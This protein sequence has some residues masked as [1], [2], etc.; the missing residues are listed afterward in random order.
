MDFPRW[1]DGINRSNCTYI[2]LFIFLSSW[3]KMDVLNRIVLEVLRLNIWCLSR[4]QVQRY[5]QNDDIVV[6]STSPYKV[7]TTVC[8]FFFKRHFIHSY[9]F[10]EEFIIV[11]SSPWISYT[12]SRNVVRY[13]NNDFNACIC[14]VLSVRTRRQLYLPSLVDASNTS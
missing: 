11:R 12:G 13:Q 8:T 6:G 1:M 14:F 4:R 2:Y 10:C 7:A 9:A 5:S 3:S